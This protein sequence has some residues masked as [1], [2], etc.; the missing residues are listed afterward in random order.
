MRH[1]T[2]VLPLHSSEHKTLVLVM[3]CAVTVSSHASRVRTGLGG[4]QGV[5]EEGGG[6]GVLLRALVANLP[7]FSIFPWPEGLPWA[8]M[9]LPSQ[10]ARQSQGTAAY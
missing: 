10:A 3:P 7:C 5:E 1:S 4:G 6:V 2:K 9:A 8:W